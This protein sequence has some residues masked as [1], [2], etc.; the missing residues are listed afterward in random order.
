[1]VRKKTSRLKEHATAHLAHRRLSGESLE[2]IADEIV[3]ISNAIRKLRATRLTEDTLLLLMQNAIGQNQK[4]KWRPVPIKTIKSVLDG[5]DNLQE[6]HL[7]P[8][9][10][11]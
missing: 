11:K 4:T 1:M 9:E 7:K 8:K 2:E 3:M 10:K 5:I 6:K